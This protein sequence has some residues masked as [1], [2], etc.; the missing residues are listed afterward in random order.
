MSFAPSAWRHVAFK[1]LPAASLVAAAAAIGVLISP[2]SVSARGA[3]RSEGAP[4]F[5][6]VHT[7]AADFGV[8]S[9]CASLS[10]TVVGDA[11]G[12]EV[13][14]ASQSAE[15]YFYGPDLDTAVWTGETIEPVGV[16]TPVVSGGM[17]QVVHPLAGA[18]LISKRMV[19]PDHGIEYRARFRQAA[20]QKIGVTN[21]GQRWIDFRT[22]EN[23]LPAI[24]LQA[25]ASNAGGTGAIV[26]S[27][28]NVRFGEFHTFRAEWD[29]ENIHYYVDDLLMATHHL[30]VSGP[31]PVHITSPAPNQ[32]AL[33]VDWLRAL[34]YPEAGTY[35]ACPFDAGQVVEW[36]ALRWLADVPAGTG[37]SGAART[38]LDGQ[39]WSDWSLV[40]PGAALD[41]PLGRYLQYR[42]ELASS[43]Y[44]STPELTEVTADFSGIPPTSTATETETEEPTPTATATETE[45]PTHTP[46]GTATS[47][48]TATPTPTRTGT[49]TESPTATMTG[50]PIL[51]F[52][53]TATGTLPPRDT[54]TTTPS[55]TASRTRTASPTVT[56]T[57][58][59]TATPTATLDATP[60]PTGTASA[61]A[62]PSPTGRPSVFFMYL[63]VILK[64]APGPDLIVSQINISSQNVQIV[65]M[66]Q[67]TESVSEGF[68]V[69]LYVDPN[70]PPTGVNQVWNDGRSV[71]GAVWGVTSPIA[72]L[73]LP[74]APGAV[75]TLTVGDVFYVPAFSALPPAFVPGMTVYVQVDSANINTNYGAVLESHETFGGP[76]NNISFM[77]V[78]SPPGPGP[79]TPARPAEVQTPFLVLSDTAPRPQPRPPDRLAP[80][81]GVPTGVR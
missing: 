43:Q 62:T 37:L 47:E 30:T 2:T 41:L 38:S 15:D 7:T 45:E 79:L 3:A 13:R 74:L 10:N 66:N 34:D 80:G 26:T 19:Y 17:V 23:P 73:A 22:P 71:Y 42:I 56:P 28:R 1:L 25:S 50:T 81:R 48:P 39:R 12:G 68:W 49:A 46:T 51:I 36:R 31:L 61:T 16:F 44:R 32:A 57:G 24:D 69:D 67:G 55:A 72:N 65:I 77:I 70:P 40:V 29:A 18:R 76:Y 59:T 20:A 4:L 63:P 78:G 33:D 53:P 5:A 52:T 14:L 64:A 35:L 54:A 27:L 60:T 21:F 9:D 58:E 11:Q 75:M 6:L 8:G